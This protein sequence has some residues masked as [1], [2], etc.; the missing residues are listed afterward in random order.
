MSVGFRTPEIDDLGL[1]G[2][3][4]I[5]PRPDSS[6]FDGVM[7]VVNAVGEPVEFCFSDIETP[8]TVLWGKIALRRRV[9]ADLVKALLTSCSSSPLLLMV[10]AGEV[11]P[12]TFGEDVVVS[13]AACRV[14][15]GLEAVALGVGDQEEDVEGTG[16]V[17]LVWS[18][19]APPAEAPARRLMARLLETGMFM[20]PFERAAAGLAE[21][22][23]DEAGGS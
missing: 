8:R 6:S 23:Q 3:V 22:R 20:E 11:G 9:A 19:E 15:T 2:Y 13:A 21:T 4:R 18:G 12:E 14:T 10:L 1:A 5:T 17:H 7:F 16:D